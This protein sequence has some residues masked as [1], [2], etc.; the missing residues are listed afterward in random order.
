MTDGKIN[1]IVS[2]LLMMDRRRA[3]ITSEIEKLY[4]DCIRECRV[5]S[6]EIDL[7]IVRLREGDPDR[8]PSESSKVYFVE[9]EGAAE[10]K[11]G[12]THNLTLRVQQLA[13]QLG[14][15]VTLVG[16]ISG[17]RVTER[18][19]HSQFRRHRRGGEIFDW[20]PIKAACLGLIARNS[21]LLPE[22]SQ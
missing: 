1:G 19:V 16:A 17:D 21:A 20:P 8:V 2:R 18:V 11:I 9:L 4:R 14:T 22:Y 10:V 13:Y 12:T 6:Q 3:Q 15:K 5:T 7:A